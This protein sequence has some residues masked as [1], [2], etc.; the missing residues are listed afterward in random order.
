MP[1]IKT[2]PP[3]D[4][5][6]VIF[7][8]ERSDN[9]DGYQEMDELTIQLANKIPGYLGYESIKSA[10][11]GIFISYWESMEAINQWRN[12]SIHQQAKIM[13]KNVWYHHYLSQICKVEHCTA[14]NFPVSA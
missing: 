5:Y 14:K 13:G 11:K 4:Y 9:L 10:N 7:I 12:H 2:L 6:A 1:L 8:S 3:K